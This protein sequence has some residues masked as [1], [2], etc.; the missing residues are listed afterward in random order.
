MFSTFPSQASKNNA[1]T[2]GLAVTV[3]NN[4]DN[5]AQTGYLVAPGSISRIMIERMF[6]NHLTLPYYNCLQDIESYPYFDRRFHDK[7]I[8]LH[9]CVKEFDRYHSFYFI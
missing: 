9:W 7:V 2:D 3:H 4:T 8:E 6:I 5:S 1:E